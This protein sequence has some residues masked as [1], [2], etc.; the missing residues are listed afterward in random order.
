MPVH[1]FLREKIERGKKLLLDQLPP[2]NPG[3]S[4]KLGEKPLTRKLGRIRTSRTDLGKV[5]RHTPPRVTP[6]PAPRPPRATPTP[7]LASIAR[8]R[9]RLFERREPRQRAPRAQEPIPTLAPSQFT[10]IPTRG[11]QRPRIR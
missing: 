3:S 10:P 1:K 6:V 8:K 11:P 5:L 4:R 7:P 2:L 9:R